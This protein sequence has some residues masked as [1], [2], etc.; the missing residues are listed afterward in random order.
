MHGKRKQLSVP[1]W[2]QK[3]LCSA[4]AGKARKRTMLFKLFPVFYFSLIYCNKRA[5]HQDSVGSWQERIS[6]GF[7]KDGERGHFVPMRLNKCALISGKWQPF[8][9]LLVELQRMNTC[10]H[11]KARQK[12]E[13]CWKHDFRAGNYFSL[14]GFA[15]I[16]ELS[17]SLGALRLL[18]LTVPWQVFL[19]IQRGLIFPATTNIT[20]DRIKQ[21]T[22]NMWL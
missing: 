5:L 13:K 18:I 2:A 4:S 9:Q 11:F 10:W 17:H 12:G 19:G 15:V 3:C 20:R 1:P 22:I 8:S 14:N 6:A 21:M 7:R 16:A